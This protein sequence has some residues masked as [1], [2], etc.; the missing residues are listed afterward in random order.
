MCT[1][2]GKTIPSLGTTEN[3]EIFVNVLALAILVITLI[4][5]ICIQLKTG[6]IYKFQTEHVI[7]ICLML[8]LLA[9]VTSVGIAVPAIK[10]H[11]EMKYNIEHRSSMIRA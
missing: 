10:R 2:M 6:A 3:K 4:V 7:V 11:L 5:D 8:L 1:L 9:I